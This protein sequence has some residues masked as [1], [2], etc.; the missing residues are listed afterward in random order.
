MFAPRWPLFV[1]E[2][3]TAAAILLRKC[4]QSFL[5]SIF[6]AETERADS[7]PD[8]DEANGNGKDQRGDG[9]NFWSD[10]AAEAAPDFERQSIVSADEE[11]SDGNLVHGER[12][13]KHAGGDQG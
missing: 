3:S 10:A 11:K 1:R 2:L 9:I 8:N 7:I 6:R 13:D 12:K 4:L 5:R